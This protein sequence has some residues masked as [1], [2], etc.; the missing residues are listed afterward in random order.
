M[1]NALGEPQTVVL[2]GG[3]SDIGLAIVRA[4]RSPALRTIVLGCRDVEAG[5]LV[6]RDLDW[7]GVT[8]DVIEFHAERH[9]AHGA[10]F[11]EVT[12]RHGDLDVVIMAV[13]VLADTEH[14]G[15]D[16]VRAAEVVNATMTGPVTALVAASAMVRRQGHGSLVVLSS[17]AGERARAS[18]AVYGGAKAGLDATAQAMAD[19]LVGSGAHLLIVRPGFVRT[20]MTAGLPDGPFATTPEAVAAAVVQG[21]RRGRRVVWVP[22]LLRYVFMVLRHL[23][24][25]VWRRIAARA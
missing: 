21:M 20:R 3:T 7:P 22:G 13:G 15:D 24:T 4:V 19:Q 14:I 12:A 18:L 10:W 23:P 1:N 9:E 2:L 25:P 8:V 17:V 5:A 11:G 6:A 16:P